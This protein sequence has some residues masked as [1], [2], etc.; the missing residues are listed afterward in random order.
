MQSDRRHELESNALAD[1]VAALADRVR[2]HARTIGLIAALAVVALA[3][4]NLVESRRAA[5]RE[6]SWDACSAAINAGQPAAVEDAANRYAGTPAAQWARL[7]LADA[8]LEQGVQMLVADRP[9]GEQRLR[10]AESGYA[11]VLAAAPLAAV[12]ERATF[13]LAK[14]RESLGFLDEARRGYEVIVRE[15]PAGPMRTFAE[16][17]ISALGRE[18]TRQWYDWIAS[19]KPV[20]PAAD[21]AAPKPPTPAAGPGE[22]GAG[23]QPAGPASPAGPGTDAPG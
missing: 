5:A 21:G 9:Q 4:W 16:E 23:E 18:S 11:G 17:R 1:S 10:A 22:P 13:G 19:Q 20:P 3:A 8:A 12:A 15:H 2:P 6:E 14:A 7:I